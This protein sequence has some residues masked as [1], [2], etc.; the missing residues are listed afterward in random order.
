MSSTPLIETGAQTEEQDYVTALSVSRRL[1]SRLSFTLGLNQTFRL[2][3]QFNDLR[4]WSA[5]GSINYAISPKLQVGLSIGA[6]YDEVSLSPSLTFE[7]YE[8]VLILN[9][10]PKT[11]VN[12]SAGIQDE[13]FGTGGIPNS[14]SPVFSAAITYQLFRHTAIAVNAGTSIS[15]SFFSN[16]VSTA[17][18]VGVSLQQQ[19]TRK[20]SLALTGGYDVSSYQSIEPGPLPKYYF[21]GTAT[22]T[23]L[24]VTRDDTTSFIGASFA[25]A[26]RPRWN[27]SASYSYSKNSSSQGAFAYASSQFTVQ[28][29]YQY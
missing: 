13:S 6:G 8:A 3:D 11:T 15:P 26:F 18:S 1:G 22:T 12:I 29:S 21:Y 16:Q 27:G 4:D 7:S 23:A 10:G 14:V 25:Y 2:A 24:Q 20:L 17:T 9:P 5:N 28:L 19:L